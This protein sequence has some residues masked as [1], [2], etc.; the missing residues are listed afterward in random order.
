MCIF[1]VP[2]HLEAANMKRVFIFMN[3]RSWLPGIWQQKSMPGVKFIAKHDWHVIGCKGS[4]WVMIAWIV[5]QN[6]RRVFQWF[7]CF[8]ILDRRMIKVGRI[9][10]MVARTTAF[11]VKGD[12]QL[13]DQFSQSC[14]L[15]TS[16]WTGRSATRTY[17]GLPVVAHKAV[18]EVSRIGKL[19]EIGCCEPWMSEQKHWP[20]D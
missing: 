13:G 4:I 2:P 19:G 9:R 18:A 15:T 11:G 16:H 5:N 7:Q 3:F 1:F 12:Q 6:L 10:G 17:R 14:P 8:W 20:T